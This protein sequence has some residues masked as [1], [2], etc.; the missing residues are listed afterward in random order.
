[1]VSLVFIYSGDFGERVIRN[2]INDPS[3]CKACG[4]LCDFC[5]Y[6]VYTFVQNICAAIELTNPT[7]LPRFIENP[8]EYLPE[9]I[10]VVDLCIATGIHQDL[11]LALPKR[12]RNEG[13]KG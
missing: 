12:L 7:K 1:M 11:L 9:R 8:E 4:L 3:F 6:G 5:K 10:P 13:I 2:V